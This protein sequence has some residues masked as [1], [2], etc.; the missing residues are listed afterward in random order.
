MVTPYMHAYMHTYIHTYIQDPYDPDHV[1]IAPL[2]RSFNGHVSVS[3][4]M[5]RVGV[6]GYNLAF[7]NCEHF[8]QYCASGEPT[9]SQVCIYVCMYVCMYVTCV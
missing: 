8:A 1:Y 2:Q 3:R 4:A 9:S 6:Q 5:S 7:A